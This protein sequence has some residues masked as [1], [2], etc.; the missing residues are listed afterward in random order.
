[1]HFSKTAGLGAVTLMSLV[2]FT[3]AP[4]PVIASLVGGVVSGGIAGGIGAG[5]NSKLARGLVDTQDLPEGVSQAHVDHCAQQI[6]A[7]ATPVQVY[8]TGADCKFSWPASEGDCVHANHPLSAARA[9]NVPQVCMDIAV[10]ALSQSAEAGG[11]VAIPRGS[12]SLEYHGLS[13]QSKQDI[14]KALN[15]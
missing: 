12:S 1:M 9:D 7:Q 10:I 15:G 3:P 5:I 14:Q 11:P 2:Q 13:E 4:L 6:N 8:S